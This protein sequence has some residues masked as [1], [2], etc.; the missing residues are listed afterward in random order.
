MKQVLIFHGSCNEDYYCS[1]EHP[2]PS[3]SHWMPWLQKE[4]LKKGYLA[5][6]PEILYA[7][8][9]TYEKYL[10]EI[11]R[12]QLDEETVLIGHSCGAGFL[13]RYLSENSVKLKKVILVAPWL[14]L[15]RKRTTDMF[16][17]KFNQNLVNRSGQ[18]VIYSSTNDKETIKDSLKMIINEIS[19]FKLRD[20]KDYG[21]FRY[22]DIGPR[23]PELLEE[24]LA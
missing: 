9:P 19:G 8:K 16:E 12:Y 13:L 1:S 24:I 14:D 21:H 15:S 11:S 2:S 4:L 20:F 6:T 5:Q 23:F 18:L 17:F 3:N 7:F 10:A 22:K